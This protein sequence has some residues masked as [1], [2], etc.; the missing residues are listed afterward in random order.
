MEYYENKAGLEKH[1]ATLEV[2]KTVDALTQEVDELVAENEKC[3]FY[4]GKF[5]TC[6]A[7]VINSSVITYF[8]LKYQFYNSRTLFC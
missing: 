6:H 8:L 3:Q 5:V 1:Q 4:S 2:G 7:I